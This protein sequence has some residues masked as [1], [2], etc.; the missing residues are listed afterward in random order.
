MCAKTDQYL[1]LPQSEFKE[2]QE[3]M[4]KMMK[5]IDALIIMNPIN[6]YYLTGFEGAGY[7]LITPTQ[8]ILYT[9]FIDK[10]PAKNA[11]CDDVIILKG[12]LNIGMIKTA[13]FKHL[14]NIGI[15]SSISY[16]EFMHLQKLLKKK[17]KRLIPVTGKVEALRLTKSEEE[18]KLIKKAA[19][20][21]DEVFGEIQKMIK[22]G[23]TEREIAIE[24]D[25]Q[26]KKK[27]AR[28]ASFEVIV[29]AGENGALPHAISGD[30][31]IKEGDMITIDMGAQ[32]KG[33]C[34]DMTRTFAVGEPSQEMKKIYKIVKEAQ[35]RAIEA[36]KPGIKVRELDK[37]ARDFIKKEGF[38]KYFGHSLGHGI[39]LQVHEAPRVSWLG[40]GE[41]K[42]N[43]VIT[44]EPGIYIPGKGG[45]RIEDMV[46]VRKEG[47]E[48]LTKS[49]KIEIL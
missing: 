16:A 23:I 37:I 30:Y 42:E 36:V 26:L 5:K 1:N 24:I 46:V 45:V 17:R 41:L 28:R 40:K 8:T 6:V 18:I 27:G 33:Y 21:S 19:E 48:I 9:G 11:V 15:E 4:R 29:A 25:Y 44:I 22:P 31:K 20:I 34:S 38:G 47:P 13:P 10:E 32:Y 3:K 49:K 12:K 39:G 2:R 14:K 7:L 43:M 35:E